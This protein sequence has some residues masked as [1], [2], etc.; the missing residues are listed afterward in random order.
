MEDYQFNRLMK[1][2]SEYYERKFPSDDT[3]AAWFEKV[4]NIPGTA[5]E[6]MQKT[7]TDRHET[8]PKNLPNCL[9]ALYQEWRKE[10][11]DKAGPF[12]GGCSCESCDN[13]ILHAR[14]TVE[15]I[16]HVFAFRCQACSR[17]ELNGLPTANEFWLQ[18]EGYEIDSAKVSQSHVVSSR[19]P[20]L[21]RKTNGPEK[22]VFEV[23]N[24]FS[25][26]GRHD[27]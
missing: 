18:R 1:S 14:K 3:R 27:V 24:G 9:W 23:M 4:K 15:G 25:F 10:H 6:W 22:A 26:D 13:G 8:F 11:P 2:L 5:V 17:S 7:I 16:S 19:A 20:K 12:A 21:S